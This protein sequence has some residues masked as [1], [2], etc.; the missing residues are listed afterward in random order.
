VLSS[1]VPRAEKSSLPADNPPLLSFRQENPIV[2]AD[3]DER[4]SKAPAAS[5]FHSTAWAKVLS[6]A[7]GFT[8]IYFTALRGSELVSAIPVMEVESWLTGKRGVS[9][10]FT[11]E[12][13]PLDFTAPSGTS[14]LEETLRVG[15]TRKWKYAEF[16]A[17]KKLFNDAPP[18]LIFLGHKLKLSADTDSLFNQFGS[19]VRRAIRKAEKAG[20]TVEF[21]Q[22]LDATRDYYS[23]HCKTRQEHGLPPQS[24]QFF[25]HIHAYI[26]ARNMGVVVSAKLRGRTVASALFFHND[27][28]A[29][30]KFG[31]SDD[32][33]LE[34]RANNL[35]MWEAIKWLGR[36]GTRLLRLGRTSADNEGL[37]RY[38]LGWGTEEY[39]INYYKYDLR[40]NALVAEKDAAAGWHNKIFRSLPMFLLRWTGS[41]LYKHSA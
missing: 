5:V 4:I 41:V 38:K 26:L 19:A 23:L 36:K 31:A 6:D 3:W 25:R 14:L 17:G 22:T 10:P 29:I 24:F 40:K 30:Y 11:D 28:E 21:S 27:S 20:L 7:Y 33:G 15:R 37:R 1:S 18:S 39:A 13:E 34:L 16:R 2:S 8:P 12:C 35:V 32:A 9:L